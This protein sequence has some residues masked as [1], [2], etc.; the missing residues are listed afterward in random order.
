MLR[1]GHLGTRAG[2]HGAGLR[3]SG[4]LRSMHGY[5][6]PL[7]SRLAT[8]SEAVETRLAMLRRPKWALL[9]GGAVITAFGIHRYAGKLAETEHRRAAY[10]TNSERT[11][12]GSAAGSLLALASDSQVAGLVERLEGGPEEVPNGLTA[13]QRLALHALTLRSLTRPYCLTCPYRMRLT[14]WQ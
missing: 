5:R 12:L 8:F 3:V 7:G 1:A 11:V 4:G 10:L 13:L 14:S 2:L 6:R 9:A